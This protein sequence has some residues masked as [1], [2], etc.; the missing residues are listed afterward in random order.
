MK[1]FVPPHDGIKR[2]A[3]SRTIAEAWTLGSTYYGGLK[4]RWR[5]AF[6]FS[7]ID[8]S[9]QLLAG[10]G[11]HRWLAVLRQHFFK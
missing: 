3:I 10:S 11:I 4:I 5:A 7:P 1:V 6:F 8:K 2:K 9:D